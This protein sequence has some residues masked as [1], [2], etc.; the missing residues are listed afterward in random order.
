MTP[1]RKNDWSEL[2]KLAEK[3]QIPIPC[4]DCVRGDTPEVMECLHGQ[5]VHMYEN[6]HWDLC[7]NVKEQEEYPEFTLAPATVTELIRELEELREA[8]DSWK[9]EEILWRGREMELLQ[10]L[11]GY[12][13]GAE[14]LI[15]QLEAAEAERDR[16]QNIIDCANTPLMA[17][18]LAERDRLRMLLQNL[19][20]WARLCHLHPEVAP[21]LL[22]EA[23]LTPREEEKNEV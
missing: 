20:S 22:A 8:I 16:L 6:D 12:D 21:M 15:S 17:E 18:V 9:K 3:A 10:D 2:K 19:Y 4:D 11:G 1:E 23:A 7:T 5:T 14:D 13:A